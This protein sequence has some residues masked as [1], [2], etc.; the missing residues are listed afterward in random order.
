M[1]LHPPDNMSSSETNTTVRRLQLK[2]NILGTQL[3]IEMVHFREIAAI[4]SI[5][6]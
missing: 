2:S 5:K 6:G 3:D 4:I 1:P